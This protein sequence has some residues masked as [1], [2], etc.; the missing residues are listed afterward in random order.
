MQIRLCSC[1]KLSYPGENPH[2]HKSKWTWLRLARSNKN[3]RVKYIKSCVA[4]SSLNFTTLGFSEPP[5]Y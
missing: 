4:R 1:L 2:I 5:P 3:S